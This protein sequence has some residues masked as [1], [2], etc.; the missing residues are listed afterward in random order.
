MITSSEYLPTLWVRLAFYGESVV[1]FSALRRVGAGC[2]G[3]PGARFSML[4]VEVLRAEA[5]N[6]G[7]HL[8]EWL[9]MARRE[10]LCTFR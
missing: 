7:V 3:L 5:E 6:P 8:G 2:V 9:L 4:T 10:R 1:F